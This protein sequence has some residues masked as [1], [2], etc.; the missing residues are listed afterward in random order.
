MKRY[1]FKKTKNKRKRKGNLYKF[2]MCL[3]A[4]LGKNTFCGDLVDAGPGAMVH[5]PPP[6]CADID[7]IRP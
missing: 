6:L 7:D 3:V 2:F 1:S 4:I 5:L